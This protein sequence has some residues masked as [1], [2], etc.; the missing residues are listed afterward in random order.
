MKRSGVPL[1]GC[2]LSPSVHVRRGKKENLSIENIPPS[3]SPE[4]SQYNRESYEGKKAEVGI[5]GG[6]T[7]ELGKGTGKGNLGKEGQKE[8]KAWEARR[9]KWWK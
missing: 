3:P 1:E 5:V 8:R 9:E 2:P 6:K 4:T 7:G